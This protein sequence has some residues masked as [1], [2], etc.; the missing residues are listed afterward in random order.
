MLIDGIDIKDYNLKWLRQHIGVVSQEPILFGTTI[1][2]NIRYGRNDATQEDIEK[3]AKEA[4][5]HDFISQ[6]PKVRFENDMLSLGLVFTGWLG[7]GHLWATFPV[8]HCD[9]GFPD[10]LSNYTLECRLHIF[11]FA[12]A[13][14]LKLAPRSSSF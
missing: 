9:P 3:A 2:E 7:F 5:A 8:L 11:S 13:E 14:P 10:V 4:N 12:S 1:A 6:L